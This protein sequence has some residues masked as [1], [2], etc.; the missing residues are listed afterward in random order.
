MSDHSSAMAPA[1]GAEA[2]LFLAIERFPALTLYLKFALKAFQK[3][4]AYKFEYFVGVANGLLFIFIF[5]SLW[6]NIF[7][8][9]KAAADI[10]F[11]RQGM[12]SYAVFAMIIRISMSQDDLGVMGKVRS[13]QIALDMIKPYNFFGATLAEN[14]GGTMFHWF[15]RAMP[16]LAVCMIFTS[17]TMPRDPVNY[18]LLILAWTLGYLIYFMVNFLFALLAFWIVETFSFQLMKYGMFTLFSGGIIPLDFF[19]DMVRPIV[20]WIPF[21]S[22]LYVPTAV[23]IGHLQGAQAAGFILFQAGWVVALG[24][25]CA[26][27]WR[28]ARKKLIIQ[29]G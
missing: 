22:V 28:A 1:P 25:C 5:T 21:M 4:L 8:T 11:S 6:K 2:R 18:L 23:F 27:T 17:V 3:Q 14:I 26:L 7:D 16:I 13:G 9:S 15:T 24:I 12:I 20:A 10:S 19:P 29:G